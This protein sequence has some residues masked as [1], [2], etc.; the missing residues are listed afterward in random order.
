[1]KI[2][3]YFTLRLLNLQ[4]YCVQNTVCLLVTYANGRNKRGYCCLYQ[5]TG[6][7]G[8]D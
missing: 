7:V 2:N 4:P 5:T 3:S 8:F 1:M 6:D